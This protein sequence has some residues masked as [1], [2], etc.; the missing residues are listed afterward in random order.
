MQLK[1]ELINELDLGDVEYLVSFLDV[2]VMLIAKNVSF[3]LTGY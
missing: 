3:I 2:V 1:I